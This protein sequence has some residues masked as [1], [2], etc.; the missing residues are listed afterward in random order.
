MADSVESIESLTKASKELRE[1][2]KKL[3]LD[4]AE[5]QKRIK[6]INAALDSNNQKIKE[7][8]SRF[9]ETEDKHR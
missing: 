7:N 6:E 5:G 8:V 3:N 4:S 1:E 9:R 2:R